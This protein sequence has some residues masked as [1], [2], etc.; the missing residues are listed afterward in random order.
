[1]LISVTVDM[2][3]AR[4]KHKRPKLTIVPR[5]VVKTTPI[6]VTVGIFEARGNHEGSDDSCQDAGFEANNNDR[7]ED[8]DLEGAHPCDC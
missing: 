3:E 5:I 1:M 4:Q 2:F 8:G 7:Y 6:P